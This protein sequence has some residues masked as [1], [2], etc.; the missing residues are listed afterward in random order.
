MTLELSITGIDELNK[1]LKGL[2]NEV[3]KKT[4]RFALRKGAKILAEKLKN[5]ARQIDDP[6]SAADIAENVAIRFSPKYYRQTGDLM[7]RVG[8]LGGAGGRK[9][10]EAFESLPGKDTRHWRHI[11]FGTS[12][13]PAQPFARKSLSENIGAITSEVVTQFEKSVDRAIKRGLK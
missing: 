5:N 10:S 11:E 1:K 2:S 8:I 13:T 7:F 12:K 4:G 9:K 3:R 6:K